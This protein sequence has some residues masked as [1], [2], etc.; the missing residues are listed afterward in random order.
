M[1]MEIAI[2]NY[3]DVTETSPEN[4][5]ILCQKI[6]S[7]ATLRKVNRM[8]Q[9]EGSLRSKLNQMRV[10]QYLPGTRRSGAIGSGVF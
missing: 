5:R 3:L 9:F 8:I 4:S 10:C 7:S 6:A 1:V 2:A